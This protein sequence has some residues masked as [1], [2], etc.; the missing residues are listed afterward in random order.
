MIHSIRTPQ[1]QAGGHA[2][3]AGVFRTMCPLNLSPEMLSNDNVAEFVDFSRWR[4]GCNPEPRT[5]NNPKPI[6]RNP[7]PR[8]QNPEPR[9][10]KASRDGHPDSATL[11]EAGLKKSTNST[12]SPRPPSHQ[13]QLRLLP[14]TYG[15]LGVP[16]FLPHEP[17][18]ASFPGVLAYSIIQE[19][20]LFVIKTTSY[21]ICIFAELRLTKNEVHNLG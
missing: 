19:R 4:G 21:R 3:G 9:I 6:T 20:K 1:G 10:H 13:N 17:D 8:T 11:Q 14:G 16:L 18:G 15:P 5:H 12:P 7:E 2:G